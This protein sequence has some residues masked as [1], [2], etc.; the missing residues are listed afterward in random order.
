MDDLEANILEINFQLLKN[1]I[2]S[3]SWWRFPK[4]SQRSEQVDENKETSQ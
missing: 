1:L 3:Q 2:Y 4:K